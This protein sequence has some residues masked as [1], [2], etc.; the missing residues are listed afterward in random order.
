MKKQKKFFSIQ[1]LNVVINNIE[2]IKNLNLNLKK[3]EIHVIMGPNGSGKSTLS[4]VVV[5]YPFYEISKGSIIFKNELISK[6]S[7]KN[8]SKLGIFLGFQY[9]LDIPVN[10]FDFLMA[11]Y[12]INKGSSWGDAWDNVSEKFYSFKFNEDDWSRNMNEG[13]S[14]GERK[15]IEI[16][17]MLLL[18]PD[19]ILLDE[20][21]SGV[22]VDSLKLISK[23]INEFMTSE[24]GLILVTHH[25]NITRYIKPDFVHIM[26]KGSIILSGGY[27]LAKKVSKEGF[28]NF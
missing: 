28:S 9:P 2:I 8:I 3:G 20:I 1:N 23:R 4:K 27:E 24:K 19:L 11:L 6:I 25:I 16:L 14:G 26:K 13:F 12:Q 10:F 17:Q 15:K 5:G 22:D 18:N 7:P 21:D